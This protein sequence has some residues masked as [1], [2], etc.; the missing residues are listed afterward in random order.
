[1]YGRQILPTV[2]AVPVEWCRRS[3][4]D[5]PEAFGSPVGTLRKETSEKE[6]PSQLLDTCEE[7]LESWEIPE[8]VEN[9]ELPETGRCLTAPLAKDELGPLI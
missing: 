3:V 2:P 4:F 8:T 5:P 6:Y 7:A 1:M 9:C